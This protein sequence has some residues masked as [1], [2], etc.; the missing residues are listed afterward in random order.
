VS[1]PR[2][3]ASASLIKA[4]VFA[5]LSGRI[6]I[7]RQKGASLIGLHLGDSCRRPP[8]GA[9]FESVEGAA[10]DDALYRYGDTTGLS[11][12][13]RAFAERLEACGHGPL[14][15]D[16]E[17]HLLVAC[18]AT[19]ALFCAMRAVL[20]PGDEVLVAAP[21]WPLAVGV[22]RAAGA[23]PI[24]VALTTRPHAR[25]GLDEAPWARRRGPRAFVPGNPDIEA[26]LER[27]LTPRTRA[28]YFAS[29]NNPDGKVFSPA[30]LEALARFA[31]KH[32][33]WTVADEVYAD[34]AYDGAHGSIARLDGMRDRTITAYSLSKACALAGARIGFAVAPEAVILAARRIGVHTV[35]NVPVAAQRVALAALRVCGTW[36]EEARSAYREAREATLHAFR[37]AGVDVP[38]PEGGSYV[39]VDFDRV[40]AGRPLRGLLELAIERGVLVAPGDGFGADFA[41]FGRVCF[42]SVEIPELL[43]GIARLRRAIDDF[44]AGGTP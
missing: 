11:T 10:F 33:L 1:I 5:D 34:Y 13:K 15:I 20:D 28:L 44:G 26:T 8:A 7:Q 30:E 25:E 16:P 37:G 4:S 2:L 3:S 36:I 41:T 19:H 43:E 31:Q 35:F 18:G 24:E 23:V 9:R 29:P 21:Y 27:A 39:F 32:D 12:L 14:G 6:E 38:C 40:L 42:T 17:R 22:I